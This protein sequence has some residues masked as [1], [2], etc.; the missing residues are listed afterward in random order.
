MNIILLQSMALAF[1]Y[2]CYLTCSEGMAAVVLVDSI[3]NSCRT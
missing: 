2:F 1:F 3:V